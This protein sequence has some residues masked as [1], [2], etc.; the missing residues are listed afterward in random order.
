VSDLP[1]F[2]KGEVQM[3]GW[4]ETHNGGCKVTF[5]LPDSEAMEP[6]RSATIKKGKI[7]G[8]RFM[9]VLVEID[10][11]EQPKVPQRHFS[12]EAHLMVTGPYFVAFCR[13]TVKKAASWDG[14]RCKRYA[15][16]L[17]NVES[18]S[19]L[20]SDPAK[21][22]IFR[23]QIQRP[24]AEWSETHDPTREREPGEDDD[25]DAGAG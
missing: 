15:K 8:Q 12:S 4:G 25:D 7:A 19:E 13:A 18:L 23:D 6:F 24:L 2:F 22:K 3:A 21:A 9:M 10:D 1:I 11:Q 20:D 16:W 14:E 17:C 5:W